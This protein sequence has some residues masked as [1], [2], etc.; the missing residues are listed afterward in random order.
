M[1]RKK[2]YEVDWPERHHVTA[3]DAHRFAAI[4]H[5]GAERSVG[6]IRWIQLP[7][8]IDHRSAAGPHE[9]VLAAARD[10]KLGMLTVEGERRVAVRDQDLD[11]ARGVGRMHQQIE[12][13]ELAQGHILPRLKRE[14][15]PLECDYLDALPAEQARQPREFAG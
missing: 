13:V 2:K 6:E 8:E 3:F 12:I 1:H 5:L 14:H 7:M 4:P 10:R 15:R 11:R 9:L